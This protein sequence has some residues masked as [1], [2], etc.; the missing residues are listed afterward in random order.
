MDEIFVRYYGMIS[1][2]FGMKILFTFLTEKKNLFGTNKK[3]VYLIF[4]DKLSW[5]H[6]K[7]TYENIA[8][9]EINKFIIAAA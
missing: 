8:Q 2:Q 9:K 1:R 5:Y 4:I 3:F 7:I 6:P